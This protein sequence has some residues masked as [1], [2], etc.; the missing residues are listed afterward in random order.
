MVKRLPLSGIRVVDFTWW[1]SG[2]E[3][4]VFLACL[5][6]EVIR[7][8]SRQRPDIMRRTS[9]HARADEPDTLNYSAHFYSLNYSKK[10]CALNLTKPEAVR[11][12]REL[13]RVS[14]I[15]VDNFTSG[16]MKRRGLDYETLREI[17]P[18]IIAISI[19][20]MGQT[21]PE[22]LY[23]SYAQTTHAFTGL[24][25][26]TG[27]E[28][29]LP[30]SPGAYWGDHISAYT[31][32][33]AV[34]AALLQRRSTG[35][36][37]YIDLS[38][39]EAVMSTLPELFMPFTINGESK[40]PRGNRNERVAPHGCYRCKGDDSWVA[41]AVDNDRE[42]RTFC[43]ALGNPAWVCAGKFDTPASRLQNQNELDKYIERWTR[44]HT[45]QEVMNI[46]Q[47]VGIAAGVSCDLERLTSDPHLHRRGFFLRRQHPKGG[48]GLQ[49]RPPWKLSG[50]PFQYYPP[51]GIGEHS[52]Y[53]LCDL[54]GMTQ[55]EFQR[56]VDEKTV[57]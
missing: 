42:W 7:I 21:G 54:L 56:L 30:Q 13:V 27:Y 32:T 12:A 11:I 36:G 3:A 57:Y 37:Q 49:M 44:K 10:S 33:F 26:I 40:K 45:P 29:G 19:T 46:L 18:G 14:D 22:S 53:V 5:G 1:Q 9:V 16:V 51:P 38:M 31:A 8:E 43:K 47:K 35:I 24:T 2:P 6:A 23:L 34:I 39:S 50:N 17:N 52:R 55:H 28:G 4:T 25:S 48:E 15:V 41:I 20:G